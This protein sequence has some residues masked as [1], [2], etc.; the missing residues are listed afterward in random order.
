MPNEPIELTPTQI[1]LKRVDLLVDGQPS[2]AWLESSVG[3][4]GASIGNSGVS[5]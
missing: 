1:D 3:V 5:K 4:K 2:N